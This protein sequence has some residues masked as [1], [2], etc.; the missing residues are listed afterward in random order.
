M[1]SFRPKRPSI[2][3]AGVEDLVM[4]DGTP[5]DSALN[6]VLLPSPEVPRKKPKAYRTPGDAGQGAREVELD[7]AADL[8]FAPPGEIDIDF[9]STNEL[10]QVNAPEARAT[11]GGDQPP[12]LEDVAE[13]EAMPGLEAD[14]LVPHMGPLCGPSPLPAPYR[15]EED[16]DLGLNT[17]E[18]SEPVDVAA[19]MGFTAVD[20]V[21]AV[22]EA[23]GQ[24]AGADAPLPED[25]PSRPARSRATIH[26]VLILA[27]GIICGVVAVVG[28]IWSRG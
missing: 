18:S 8:N 28:M 26:H 6:S 12:D 21:D 13:A 23:P 2:E 22:H 5:D 27:F 25:L 15:E 4:L 10:E 7:L 9:T 19:N 1:M 20:A 11:V 14:M 24:G 17:R 3:T 16:L